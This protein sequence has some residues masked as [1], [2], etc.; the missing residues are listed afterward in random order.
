VAGELRLRRF[1]LCFALM[2]CALGVASVSHAQIRSVLTRYTTIGD[3]IVLEDG[4]EV[5]RFDIDPVNPNSV[6]LTADGSRLWVTDRSDDTLAMIDIEFERIG[7][8][9]PMG[10]GPSRVTLNSTETRAY[11]VN[12]GDES[13]SIVDANTYTLVLLRRKQAAKHQL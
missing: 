7:V 8:T 9:M 10:D 11:V 1:V 2:V 12:G 13:V 5:S 6:A 3:V 4:V